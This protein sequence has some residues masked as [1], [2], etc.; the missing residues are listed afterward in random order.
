MKT[1]IALLRGINVSGHHKIKMIELRQLFNGLNFKNVSTYIQSG[2]VIFTSTKNNISK[3]ENSIIEA[4]KI[5]FGYDVKVIVI[6]KN[7]LGIIFKSNPFLETSTI[8]I[9]KLSV[10]FLKKIPNLENIPQIEELVLNTKDDFKLIEKSI[11]L[12]LPTGAAKTKLTNN[13]FE[14]KLKIDA[15]TRNWKTVTKL[16][17]LSSQTIEY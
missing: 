10:T 17:E 12:Y 5:K 8:E 13:L 7:E 11:Y 15:T 16:V 2:N 1:Y 4:V 3:I 9:T 14:R 6:T